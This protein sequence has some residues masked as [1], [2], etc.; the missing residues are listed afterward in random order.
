[1]DLELGE[2]ETE[3]PAGYHQRMGRGL[4][5]NRHANDG[6]DSY[7]RPPWKNPRAEI[8]S[9]EDFANRPRVT[10]SESFLT[11][12]DAMAVLSWMSQEDKDG[13]YQLYIEMMMSIASQSKDI[14]QKDWGVL[15]ANTSHE[16]AVRVVAQ[17]Y[18]VTTSRAA[19]VIQLQHNEEQ[20]KA[21]PNFKVN[22]ALQAHMD[23]KMREH[24]REVYK[25]YGETD[26]L[27]FV[28]DPLA[29]TGRIGRKDQ[30]SDKVVG[31]SELIDVDHLLKKTKLQEIE[32]AQ[33]RIANHIYV[34]D[35]DERTRLVKQDDE[36][37]RLLNI[38]TKMNNFY[39]EEEEKE[40]HN[41]SVDIDDDTTTKEDGGSKEDIPQES[42]NND[43]AASATK[44]SISKSEPKRGSKKHRTK[45]PK[46]PAAASPF[47][48]NNRGYNETPKTRRP[49]WKF[50]AQIINTHS[51]ENPRGS[52]RSGKKVAARL[53]ARRHGR[54]IDGNTVIEEDGELRVASVA[55]LERTS[56]KHVRNESEFMFRGVKQAWLKRQL[57]GEVGGW[58]YQDEVNKPELIEGNDD[59]DK[60]EGDEVAAGEEEGGIEDK[61]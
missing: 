51:L 35:V 32:K 36:M 61:N 7:W 53:K 15:S 11:M 49:R 34:E 33:V 24:I 56:W 48:E 60:D 41:A 8:I 16:Y 37:R 1:M 10:F 28:E 59:E 40:D 54:I 31:A 17:K 47:P 50:V 46:A 3:V 6:R 9:A 22:H 4:G 42:A 20:L 12:H 57:E 21:D 27:Q 2:L 43:K 19:G 25:S 52:S 26:P 39:S 30:G 58:G 29:S 38:R 18:N 44:K 55:E 23:V 13:M 5:R 45:V 14:K